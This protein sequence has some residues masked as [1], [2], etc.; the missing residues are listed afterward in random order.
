MYI[1]FPLLVA[2][3]AHL[4]T[5]VC[6]IDTIHTGCIINGSVAAAL[7]LLNNTVLL[8]G[9]SDNEKCTHLGECMLP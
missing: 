6:M 8:Y 2:M 7:I 5:P 9:S 1:L 3:I 4:M